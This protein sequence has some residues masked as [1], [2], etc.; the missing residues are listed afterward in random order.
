MNVTDLQI[1]KALKIGKVPIKGTRRIC[2][3]RNAEIA[4]FEHILAFIA[5]GGFES[6]F[7]RGDY[8]SGKTFMCSVMRELAFDRGMVVSIVN[9]SREMPFGK[10]DFVV[11]EILRGLRTPNSGTACALD[12]ILQ[13]WFGNY[14]PG[15]PL[16][17]NAAL[18]GATKKIAMGDAG[19]AMALRAYY[20][21]YC[22]GND[23][24]MQA[25]IAWLGG[26]AIASE[27][28]S[29]L[30]VVGKL[31]A[32]VAFR[33][34]R[35]VNAL[36]RDAGYPGLVVLIDEVESVMRLAKPQRD[37]AYTAMRELVDIGSEEFPH[38]FFLFAGTQ[39]FF[40]DEFK[41]V[42]SY[43]ALYQRIRSQQVTSGR[44]LRQPIIR[45]EEFDGDALREVSA[46]IREIHG[47]A[48][49]WNAVANFPDEKMAAFIK[50]AGAKFGEIRQKPRAYLKALVDALDA[51][52]QHLDLA[53]D[54]ILSGAVAVEK[55]DAVLD[56]DFVE[57][58]A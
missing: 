21:A 46:R 24:L 56:D 38:S 14:E 19:L 4:E 27:L 41:G 22:E 51:R 49:D 34:L 25:A 36:M 48:Y 13:T 17:T 7:L 12:E 26:Q 33:R 43:A 40:E 18:D 42:A 11:G 15:T 57:A 31:T 39:P 2:V 1:I 50:S 23:A 55:H 47:A 9:L 5:A 44:D 52:N 35:G 32:D 8:G 10:R 45:L 20:R 30:K 3:G 54:V 28:R 58:V 53:D 6:R 16:E 29:G 37:A